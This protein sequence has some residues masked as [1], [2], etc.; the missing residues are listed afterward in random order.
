MVQGLGFLSKKSWHTKNLNNQEKVWIAEQQQEQERIR[1][2]ELAKQIQIEREQN[3]IN[4]IT[5]GDTN[6]RK[7]KIYDRG[8]D[9]MYTGQT[10]DSQIAKEDAQK[11]AEEYLLGK[12]IAFHGAAGSLPIAAAGIEGTGTRSID[13]V[14]RNDAT[15][16]T[17]AVAGHLKGPDD[18]MVPPPP[19]NFQPNHKYEDPMYAVSLQ[20]VRKERM[21]EHQKEL[22][23]KVGI[24]T[25]MRRRDDGSHRDD[26]NSDAFDAKSP[27]RSKK[28]R[29]KKKHSSKYDSTSSTTSEEED[30]KHRKHS[31]RHSRH[32][33]ERSRMS[34]KRKRYSDE[35]D[36]ESSDSHESRCSHLNDGNKQRRRRRQKPSSYNDS[37]MDNLHNDLR[38]PSREYDQGENTAR[39][40]PSTTTREEHTGRTPSIR[41]GLVTKNNPEL[42]NH[43][44]NRRHTRTDDLGPDMELLQRKREE[45]D[46]SKNHHNHPRTGGHGY[47]N[48]NHNKDN[49]SNSQYGTVD[50][51]RHRN[52][53]VSNPEERAK[54]LRAMEENA[55]AFDATRRQASTSNDRDHTSM[56][57]ASGTGATFLHEISQ[58]VHGVL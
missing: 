29:K 5:G 30:D 51:S 24:A 16:T 25:M 52:H 7:K 22:Y 40:Y 47:N 36:D 41:Y 57:A 45:K 43:D 31:K 17:P 20:T 23:Q 42:A 44:S 6:T 10:K 28:K 50:T 32:E 15:I 21:I 18:L 26:N 27:K 13:A 33:K 38:Y 12:P 53:R 2:T 46:R 48:V 54:A 35:D 37:R 58:Q 55:K 49:R 11:I 39:P 9:W 8:I 3:E 1:T 19:P 34:S 56:G 14:V 4:E